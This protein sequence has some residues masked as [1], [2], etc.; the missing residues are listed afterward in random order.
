MSRGFFS[1]ETLHYGLEKPDWG[2]KFLKIGRVRT[3]GENYDLL[4]IFV[5]LVRTRPMIFFYSH[6][7]SCPC[8]QQSQCFINFHIYVFYAGAVISLC[9]AILLQTPR[10]FENTFLYLDYPSKTNHSETVSTCAMLPSKYIRSWYSFY[11]T[12]YFSG[13]DRKVAFHKYPVS[14]LP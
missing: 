8:L 4:T 5:D 13:M 1:S 10:L 9:S 12:S 3:N 7:L 14:L 11:M 2:T 6:F